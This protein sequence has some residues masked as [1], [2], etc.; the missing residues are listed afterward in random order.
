MELLH[1]S[2]VDVNTSIN[3]NTCV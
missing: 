2:L 3:E 1:V